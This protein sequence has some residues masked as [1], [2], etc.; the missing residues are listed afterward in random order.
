M[1]VFPAPLTPINTTIMPLS[2]SLLKL[3]SSF[4]ARK[5]QTEKAPAQRFRLFTPELEL[6]LISRSIDIR[7]AGSGCPWRCSY[8]PRNTGLMAIE[9]VR[10]HV[11]RDNFLIRLKRLQIAIAHLG[12]DLEAHM[13]QLTEVRVVLRV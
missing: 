4:S 3:F 12:R 6:Y 2:W 10:R 8:R 11:L 7:S 9:Q 13:Q 5:P 1:V